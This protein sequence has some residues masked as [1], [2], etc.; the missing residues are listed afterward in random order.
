VVLVFVTNRQARLTR[1][2]LR[3][4]REEFIAS[5]RPKIIIKHIWLVA[6]GSNQPVTVKIVYAN[7]GDAKAGVSSIGMDFNI[8]NP[9]AQLPGDLTAPE[10]PY[11][12]Y[13]EC[14]LGA[15]ASTNVS[16][17]GSLNE[18]KVEAIRMGEKLLCCFG[19]VEY[20]DTGPKATRKI[21]RS[22]FCRIYKP[23][24]RPI[25]GMGRFVRPKESDPDYEYED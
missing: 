18:Q 12:P 14:G 19:F 25:D 5:H 23:S 11:I 7:V 24:A 1:D 15:T 3:L 9:D 22:A 21:R 13:L 4:A 17:L 2:S 10:R 16:S 6:L 8:I 20:S